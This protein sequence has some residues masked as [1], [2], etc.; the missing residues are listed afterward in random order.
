MAD[1]Q[2]ETKEA[3]SKH[4]SPN[5]PCVGLRVAVGKIEG[6]YK[7]DSLAASQKDA[8]LKHMGFENTQGDAARVLS[9]VKSFGL[10]D[11]V[12]G[13]RVKISQ[14]GVDI[15]ARPKGDPKRVAALAAAA[16]GPQVYRDILEMAGASGSLPSDQTLKSELIAVKKFNPKSVDGLLADFRDTMDFAGLSDPTALESSKAQDSEGES[17]PKTPKVGDL[18]QWESQGT[19][20]FQAKRVKSVS[21]DG[22]WVFVDGSGTGLPVNELT[23]VGSTGLSLENPT[24]TPLIQKNAG[25]HSETRRGVPGMREDIF[26]L[27]EGTVTLQCPAPLT[28]ESFQDL[29]EWLD[30]VKRK[31]GRSMEKTFKCSNVECGKPFEAV[32]EANGPDRSITRICPYCHADVEIRWPGDNVFLRAIP[33]KM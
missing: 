5:Y 19:I 9:A 30:L 7:A 10:I 29:A 22:S 27:T 6:L 28:P 14:R 2:E 11:E 24:D 3:K 1:K 25:V 33:E 31:I 13:G 21:P 26:S 23:I 17:Q 15:V 18:V 20:R 4:R 16:R 8:A 32:G 12:D